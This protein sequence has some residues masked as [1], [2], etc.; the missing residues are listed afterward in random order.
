M[1]M[2]DWKQEKKF[3]N[4]LSWIN[5]RLD[6]RLLLISM[7]DGWQIFNNKKKITTVKT[8]SKALLKAKSYM[9]SH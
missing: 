9:R 7:P 8:K 2:K 5:D 4:E 1:A 3:K 6:D